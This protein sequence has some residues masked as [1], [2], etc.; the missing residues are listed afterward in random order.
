[1]LSPI[2]PTS[3]HR[4][5]DNPRR[6]SHVKNT[7]AIFH[8]G[9]RREVSQSNRRIIVLTRRALTAWKLSTAY[10]VASSHAAVYRV[11][12]V[13]NPACMLSLARPA[14]TACGYQAPNPAS[15][16]LILLL[17]SLPRVGSAAADSRAG[18]RSRVLGP[19]YA[20]TRM[21]RGRGVRGH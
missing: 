14:D 16:A 20:R 10:A 21:G 12:R 13:R 15:I 6:T 2:S 1:N 18:V 19:M 9:H 11:S 5:G 7:S 3:A 8:G 17:R 4:D